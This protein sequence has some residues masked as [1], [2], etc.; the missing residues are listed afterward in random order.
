VWRIAACLSL[1]AIASTG[2]GAAS[3]N[4]GEC[5]GGEVHGNQCVPYTAAD[6]AA[7]I[8]SGIAV[9]PRNGRPLANIKCTVRGS[10]ADCQGFD[11]TGRLIRA[12]FRIVTP[13][14]RSETLMPICPSAKHPDRPTSV[15]CT[16]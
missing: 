2:C 6:K 8:L 14:H 11:A 5:S 15:F 9:P 7:L 4:G 13:D 12:Q 3:L 1:L 10:V 16:Q